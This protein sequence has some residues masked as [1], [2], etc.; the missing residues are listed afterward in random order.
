MPAWIGARKLAVIPAIP[1]WP[2]NTQVGNVP[3]DFQSQVIRRI[4]YDPLPNTE[5]PLPNTD[6]DGSLRK[7]I[8]SVSYGRAWLDADVLPPVTVVWEHPGSDPNPSVGADVGKTMHHAIDA[9]QP[10]VAGYDYVMVVFPPGIP[11]IRSWAFYGGGTQ[12]SSYV[13]LD[14]PL[15]A[16]AMELLHMVTEFGDLYDPPPQRPLSP[17]NLDE[18]DT[19]G[20]M[21][22]S[23]FTKLRMGWLD[24]S[25]VP[26]IDP[27]T[28]PSEHVS[29]PLI[30]VV[31]SHSV[32]RLSL[33][34]PR[35]SSLRT[36]SG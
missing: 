3:S 18:M 31:H 35:A 28:G 13:F 24:P 7:Y 9:S 12:A 33:T 27:Q 14:N 1:L 36:S 11:G 21:H 23:S 2:G 26:T 10:A 32:T 6:L 8:F 20:A 15:G 25:S 22:P 16:W 19:A 29:L 17:G 30:D 34:G 5:H 4:F